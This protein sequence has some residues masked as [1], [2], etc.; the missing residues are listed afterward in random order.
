MPFVDS[1][2]NSLCGSAFVRSVLMR[3]SIRPFVHG[4]VRS[5]PKPYSLHSLNPKAYILNPPSLRVQSKL[6]VR[7]ERKRGDGSSFGWH[8]SLGIYNC[9]I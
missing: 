3:S 2:V 6:Q 9:R 8:S 7:L 5:F 1:F 4:F